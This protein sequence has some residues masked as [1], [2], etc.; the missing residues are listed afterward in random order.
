MTSL[1]QTHETSW[2]GIYRQYE[3]GCWW[4]TDDAGYDRCFGSRR[5][6]DLEVDV[7]VADVIASAW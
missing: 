3:D 2:I 1:S 7:Y 5:P 4:I 6:T